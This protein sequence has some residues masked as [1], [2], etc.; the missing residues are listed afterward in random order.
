MEHRDD[1][2]VTTRSRA[3]F[4]APRAIF[5][6]SGP[7]L[8]EEFSACGLRLRTEAPLHPDEELVVRIAGE[9]IPLHARVVW[10]R[11]EPP[12]HVGGHKTWSAGC[13]LDSGSIGRVHLGPAVLEVRA[14]F[15]SRKTL[16]VLGVLGAAALLVYLFLRVALILSLRLGG[17]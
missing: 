2:R 17:G 3:R 8:V 5:S 12:L 16:P 14:P 9:A 1:V 15:L 13:R 7:A 4:E 10:V 11:E 6:P